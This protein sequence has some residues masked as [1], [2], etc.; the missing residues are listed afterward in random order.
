MKEE[1]EKKMKED[2]RKERV[3]KREAEDG[4]AGYPA[5]GAAEEADGVPKAHAPPEPGTA[6]DVD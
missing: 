5:D 4:G 2:E 3:R 1:E 6:E